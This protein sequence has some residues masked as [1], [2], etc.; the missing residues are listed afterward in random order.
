MRLSFSEITQLIRETIHAYDPS[1]QII[2]YGSRAR[3]NAHEDSDWDVLTII[4][5]DRVTRE[6]MR[7]M[8]C[9]L[10][11]RGIDIGEEINNFIY[12]TKQWESNMSMF[13]F[14]VIDEGIML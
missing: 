7:N 4:D 5:R 14:H 10:W 1:A 13:K 12:T 8:S 3:G 9:E 6:D 2:L 11:E